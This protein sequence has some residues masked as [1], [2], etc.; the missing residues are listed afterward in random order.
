MALGKRLINTGGG[1]G[2]I[3]YVASSSSDSANL[4]VNTLAVNI[5]AE[6]SLGDLIVVI[7]GHKEGSF[8]QSTAG[9]G[10]TFVHQANNVE[11]DYA[12]YY[13]I[14]DGTEP[15]TV[16]FSSLSWADKMIAST[17]VL[18]GTA[19]SSPIVV[20]TDSIT[21]TPYNPSHP[22]LSG[23][24]TDAILFYGVAQA[25]YT[26]PISMNGPDFTNFETSLSWR[27]SSGGSDGINHIMS[28]RNQDTVLATA[29]SASMS[30]P[31]PFNNTI[32]NQFRILAA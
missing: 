14:S 2:A 16:S 10:F 9:T 19:T 26:Y 8:S 12:I 23:N 6:R 32:V 24:E 31:A 27:P 29:Q 15:T 4:N 3:S 7:T 18:S 17:F 30:S 22:G 25:Q 20:G 13:K 5:P 28:L 21:S 1:G 11:I